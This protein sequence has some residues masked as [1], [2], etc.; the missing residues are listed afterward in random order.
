MLAT[1]NRLNRNPYFH[2]HPLHALF[3][4]VAALVLFA[5][6][7]WFLAIPAR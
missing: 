4:L 6:L 1:R 3:S 2:F 7:V 5:F